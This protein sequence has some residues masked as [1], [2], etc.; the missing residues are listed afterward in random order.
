MW[1]KRGCDFA[2][3]VAK[4]RMFFEYF[5]RLEMESAA[6]GA[7]A[8]AGQEE[9]KA[10]AAII[11]PLALSE[12]SSRRVV[13]GYASKEAEG[14]ALQPPLPPS[15][16]PPAM[17]PLVFKRLVATDHERDLSWADCSAPLAALRLAPLHASIDD[18]TGPGYVRC[19]FA[20]ASIGGGVLLNTPGSTAQEEITFAT[21]PELCTAKLVAE[22]MRDDEALLLLGARRFCRSSGYL[23]TFA[24]AGVADDGAAADAPYVA[25]DAA[26]YSDMAPHV[27]FRDKM[28]KRDLLKALVGFRGA[29]DAMGTATIAT[30][31]WGCGA[32]NGCPS[33]KVVIQML[34]A[35]AAGAEAVLFHAHSDPL[36]FES[37]TSLSAA[38]ENKTV[39]QLYGASMAAATNTSAPVISETLFLSLVEEQLLHRA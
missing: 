34:A 31:C 5:S 8:G 13:G 22:S 27:Q 35:S 21:H 24:F 12:G 10:D 32:F 7:G 1:P 33:V 37:L 30:G 15:R 6:E 29:V 11:P 16:P 19:D 23:E 2:P 26:K 3:N 28:T 39:G 9:T 17:A 38:L 20:N 18:A 4:L 14:A 36:L 25:I